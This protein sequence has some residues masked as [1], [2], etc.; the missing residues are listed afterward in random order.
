MDAECP[1]FHNAPMR[2]QI[3]TLG[4]AFLISISW[5]ATPAT[6]EFK[7]GLATAVIT[8]TEPTWL[9][10][11]GAR[12][13]PADG[14][15]HD[16]HAKVLILQDSG[17]H[18]L[19]L[20]TIDTENVPRAFADAV[21]ADLGRRFELHREQIVVSC[22]HT[23]SGPALAGADARI[24]Y[25]MTPEQY[26]FTEKY[27]QWLR[28]KLVT[29][30]AEAMEKLAPAELSYGVGKCGFGVNRRMN[31]EEE[32]D[33]PGF[34]PVGP[35]DHEVPVL[36]LTRGEK[37]E[38]VLFGY[39]C[40]CTTMN[41][42][43]WCGDWAGFAKIYVEEKHPGTTALFMA[44]CGADTNPLP[45]RKIELCENYGRQLA[46][47]VEQV[48]G[49]SMRPIDGSLRA[50]VRQID[51]AF[52]SLPSREALDE[53]LAT[54]NPF[55]KRWAKH[56]LGQMGG[57]RP[58]PPTYSYSVQA[59]RLGEITMIVLAGEVVVDYSLRLKKELGPGAWV[60][61]YCNDVCAYIP[62]ERVLKEGGYEGRDA[63]VYYG[64]PS[65]WAPGLEDRI[66]AA[67]RE[68]VKELAQMDSQP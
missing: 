6:A 23:H 25:P 26:A 31:K 28:G 3:L 64:L 65:A 59:V 21:A 43:K 51:L 39:A 30:T 13:Q 9:G 60:F 63:M 41:F 8:P 61:A 54:G 55:Q 7:A 32:T 27:T 14:K 50:T 40:H 56:L 36:R 35:V 19:A 67:V 29:L 68:M 17:G 44:G 53:K 11:Y 38:A 57:G 18:R 33:K 2:K 66:V 5:L 24:L 15:I 58:L 49:G 34:V 48:L 42:Q 4:A 12:T 62:S 45:R 16:L 52:E 20:L 46:D 47:S 10:G 22:S 1:A 37:L